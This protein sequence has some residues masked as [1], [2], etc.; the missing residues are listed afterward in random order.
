MAANDK[1]NENDTIASYNAREIILLLRNIDRML[2]NID[3]T[4]KENNALLKKADEKLQTIVF[5]TK[6]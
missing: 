3:H 6:D 1:N 5:N 4:L 2:T